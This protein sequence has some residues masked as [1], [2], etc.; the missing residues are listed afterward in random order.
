[1]EQVTKMN[2]KGQSIYV[3][4]DVHNKSW[5]ATFLVDEID[6]YTKTFPPSGKLLGN[7]LR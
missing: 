1:M 3:G 4:I 6:L 2:F 5:T 7:Y